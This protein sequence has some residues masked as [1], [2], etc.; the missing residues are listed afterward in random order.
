VIVIFNIQMFL[1]YVRRLTTVC[2]IVRCAA[3]IICQILLEILF[4][5]IYIR[6]V[7]TKFENSNSNYY[8][9]LFIGQNVPLKDYEMMLFIIL[10]NIFMYLF[11][12]ISLVPIN[13][14]LMDLAPAAG[15]QIVVQIYVRRPTVAR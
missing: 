12:Y 1:L 11:I 13:H 3:F 8:C 5:D 15:E 6:Y 9:Q 4:H 14:V 2:F 10:F 7:F